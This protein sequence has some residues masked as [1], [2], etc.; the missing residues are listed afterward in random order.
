[1]LIA[2]RWGNAA[3]VLLFL[4]PVLVAA[5]TTGLKSALALAVVA[6]LTFN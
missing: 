6:S 5:R 4:P 2:P 1:M 3:V